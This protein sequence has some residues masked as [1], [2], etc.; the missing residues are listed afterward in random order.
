MT[1]EIT[2]HAPQCLPAP[3]NLPAYFLPAP[4]APQCLPGPQNPSAYCSAFQYLPDLHLPLPLPP[5]DDSCCILPYVSHFT[6]PT[7]PSTRNSL[8]SASAQNNIDSIIQFEEE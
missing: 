5:D 6:V 1:K 8:C 7:P 4:H 2:A 3:Q